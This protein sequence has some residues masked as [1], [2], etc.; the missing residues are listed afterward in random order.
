MSETGKII[1]ENALHLVKEL[2]GWDKK[3][4]AKHCHIMITTL[5]NIENGTRGMGD[6]VLKRIA[7]AIG[8]SVKTVICGGFQTRRQDELPETTSG[9]PKR[10]ARRTGSRKGKAA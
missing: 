3:A 2:H 7:D 1:W 6:A 5:N 4:V 8:V 9:A 10:P